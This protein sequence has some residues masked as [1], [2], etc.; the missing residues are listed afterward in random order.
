M[1]LLHRTSEHAD[2][3]TD[4]SEP[5]ESRASRQTNRFGKDY[6]TFWNSRESAEFRLLLSVRKR[7]EPDCRADVEA[8]TRMY[9]DWR[10]IIIL[11][12]GRHVHWE[13]C[14]VCHAEIL[15]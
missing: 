9:E 8:V 2:K 13:M 5:E 3:T 15:T 7:R 4:N 11:T 12:Y 14:E 1:T 10:F 6:Q